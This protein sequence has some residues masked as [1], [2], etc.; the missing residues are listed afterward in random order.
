MDAQPAVAAR[1]VTP[2]GLAAPRIPGG[3]LAVTRRAWF[4]SGGHRPRPHLLG[5]ARVGALLG[6]ALTLAACGSVH[7]GGSAGETPGRNGPPSNN[8]GA[9]GSTP[10]FSKPASTGLPPAMQPN[11]LNP[12]A[13]AVDLR[14][15]R[16]QRAESSGRL[17]TVH[18]AI[19]GRPE[20]FT[21]GRVEVA[22]S[23]TAVTVRVLVGR[24][25]GVDCSGAQP[26]LAAPAT[27][28]VTLAR[29]L[30]GRAVVDGSA[31]HT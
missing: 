2:A 8:G 22:E 28:V 9:V 17:L 20:C 13:R 1:P 7:S 4:G 10:T 3:R 14:A 30:G 19:T 26:Q 11:R 6:L 27:V 31:P 21:L 5:A 25:P 12:D 15:V 18:F 16:W 23:A 29:D 24:L